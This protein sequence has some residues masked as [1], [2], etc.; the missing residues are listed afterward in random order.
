[1]ASDITAN[2]SHIMKIARTVNEAETVLS[3][4]EFARRA[5]LYMGLN[6]EQWAERFKS[7]AIRNLL[8]D[9]SAKEYESYWLIVVYSFFASGNAAIVDGGSIKIADSLIKTYI[10]EGGRIEP[11]M[12]AKEIGLKKKKRQNKKKRVRKKCAK[13]AMLR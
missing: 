6:I 7:E 4:F 10:K 3:H 2:L 12:A 9:F 8:L 13:L 11:N 5:V 1:M